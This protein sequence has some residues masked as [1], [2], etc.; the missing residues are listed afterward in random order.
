MSNGSESGY[1]LLEVIVVIGIL[2]SV[3]IPMLTYL[4]DSTEQIADT[5]LETETINL[6][7]WKLNLEQSRDFNQ[8]QDTNRRS[9]ASGYADFKYQ[10]EVD[11]LSS[12]LKELISKVY[13]QGKL[14]AKLVTVISR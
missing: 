13:Y 4:I 1:V 5:R 6:A 10:I 11:K 14:K 2:G 9:F 3:L 12:E 7:R 8:I